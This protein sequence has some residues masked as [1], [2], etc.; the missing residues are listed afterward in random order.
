LALSTLL[1]EVTTSI[2]PFLK[3]MALFSK[4]DPFPKC[5]LAF[6]IKIDFSCFGAG[7]CCALLTNDIPNINVKRTIFL[8]IIIILIYLLKSKP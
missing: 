4:T 6:R 2:L 8:C 7:V 1:A 5:A 3:P